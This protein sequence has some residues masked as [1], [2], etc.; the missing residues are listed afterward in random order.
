[1]KHLS[2]LIISMFILCI[3]Y[4]AAPFLRQL[5]MYMYGTDSIERRLKALE[6]NK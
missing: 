4:L 3:F 2:F 5:N 1:M 6:E